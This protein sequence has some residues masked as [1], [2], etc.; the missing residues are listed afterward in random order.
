MKTFKN[1]LGVLVVLTFAFSLSG[2]MVA[3][4]ATS[5]SLGA[6]ASYSVLSGAG[7]TNGGSGQTTIS[8]NF[9][10]YPA[11]SY[12]DTAGLPTVFST[13]GNPHLGTVP[14]QNAQAAQ[15]AIFNGPGGIEA[16]TQPCTVVNLPTYD[17]TGLTLNPGVY[18][19]DVDFLLHGTLTLNGTGDPATDVWIFRS[20]RD[21][22]G[23]AGAN[24]VFSG[25]GGLP[26]NVWW[27]LVRDATFTAD[28]AIV[29]NILAANSITFGQSATLDGR[30]FAYTAAV[31]LLGNTISGPTC[32]VPTPAPSGGNRQLY[33][34]LTV[35]KNV[36]NDNGGVKTVADFPLFANGMLVSS[37][38]ANTIR[39]D[40]YHITETQDSRYTQTFSG[41]CSVSGDLY[42]NPG[43]NKI[44]LIT[45]NDIGAP[46]VVPPVP[47]LIDVVKVPSPL[48]LPAGPGLVTYTYTLKNIGTVPVTNV[49]MIDDSCGPTA[50]ISGD[51]NS[52]SKLDVTET[53]TYR[54]STNLTATHTN[55][56]VAT[57][58][59]NSISA[60]DIAYATVVVGAPVVPPL[61]HVTKVPNP[62][63]L[64]A[65]GGLVTYT[66][67]I[68]NPGTV[69]LSNVKLVDDK[70]SPM[71]FI[72]GDINAD[73]KL[74]STETWT[75]TCS[76]KLTKTT[77]NTA[78]ATG[79]ANG[80]TVR[81]FAIA[82]V[83]VAAVV[84]GLPNTGFAPVAGSVWN[85]VAIVGLFMLLSVSIVLV[86]KKR[87]I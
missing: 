6:A 14:A 30:A 53:W 29:G 32:S 27:R 55:T 46:V 58:W 69:A 67:K 38:V 79:E 35:I 22:V 59:A 10:V 47:P 76:V 84:P 39:T 34:N 48:A 33:G 71:K 64:L 31:T 87:N 80:L 41:D 26:C 21:F 4:A 42:V 66:E 65:G 82:T 1:V 57:G 60:T 81:D 83:V 20:G 18:C 19:T 73:Q 15:L 62:L 17:L 85:V 50:L 12:T 9:G 24:I 49:T 44:C 72:G 23:T 11:S 61:I 63:T 25:T 5:P 74:D 43:D 52:D 13:V 68:T 77:S 28:N 86:I 56:V 40:S 3:Q 70:C 45:N 7:A 51:T 2:S 37:S 75:Y 16:G 8:G 36:I 78:V 54:C